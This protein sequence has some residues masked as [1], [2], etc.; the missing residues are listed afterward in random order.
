MARR[1][2]KDRF[3]KSQRFQPLRKRHRQTVKTSNSSAR[4]LDGPRRFDPSLAT[5]QI[6]R[7]KRQRL[8]HRLRD[9]L[10]GRF[11]QIV[12]APQRP[13]QRK[14]ALAR[15]RFGQKRMV[16]LSIIRRGPALKLRRIRPVKAKAA[17][18]SISAKTRRRYRSGPSPKSRKAAAE[19][20]RLRRPKTNRTSPPPR[21]RNPKGPYSRR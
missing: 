4:R 16:D 9:A 12:K 2:G 7:A 21:P 11:R 6:N 8:P 17:I 3:G 10:L 1:S 13:G 5:R 19:T 18:R 20:W 14:A 15:M